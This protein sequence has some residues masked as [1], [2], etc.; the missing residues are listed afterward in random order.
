MN[1]RDTLRHYQEKKRRIGRRTV[2]PP[3]STPQ[4]TTTNGGQRP[5]S[6]PRLAQPGE[7]TPPGFTRAYGRYWPIQ[8]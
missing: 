6:Y 3:V 5:A 2:K 8:S 1:S 4:S 7:P